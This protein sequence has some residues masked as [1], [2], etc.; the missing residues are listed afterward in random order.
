M[1]LHSRVSLIFFFFTWGWHLSGFKHWSVL[2]ALSTFRQSINYGVITL[3]H[4]CVLRTKKQHVVKMWP[5]LTLWTDR[6]EAVLHFPA[7]S[8]LQ[9]W[10]RPW[11]LEHSDK[12]SSKSEVVWL[13][14]GTAA[15]RW[16]DKEAQKGLTSG[17]VDWSARLRL[18]RP[19]VTCGSLIVV[20]CS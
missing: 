6:T 10:K 12:R 13:Q 1:E 15:A 2:H 7:D 8:E 11:I 19:L 16:R 9:D 5:S 20:T 3:K 4:F 14:E 18:R 17:H